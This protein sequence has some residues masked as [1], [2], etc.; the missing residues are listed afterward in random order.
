[1]KTGVVKWFSP[2]KGYGFIEMEEEGDVFVHYTDINMPGFKTL[3]EGSGV[4]F[5]L[6]QGDRGFK[7]VNVIKV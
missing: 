1:M 4:I 6:E 7:A 2:R 3:Y 5:D